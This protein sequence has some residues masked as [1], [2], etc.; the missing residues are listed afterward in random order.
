MFAMAVLAL[1]L[2]TAAAAEGDVTHLMRYADVHGDR[3]V[4]TYEGDLW[5]A[6]TQGGAARRLTSDPGEERFAKFSPDGT[7][8]AFTASYDGGTDVYVMDAGGGAPV[9]F[10]WHPSQD[11][12]LDWF[13]DGRSILFRSRREFPMRGEQIYKVSADGG[14]ETKLPVD[15][16][17]LT[18]LSPDGTQICYNRISGENATWK[19]HQGGDAQSLWLGS[20]AKG[21]F[22]PVAPWKGTTNYPMW[23][24]DT[25]Y[26]SSD[27]E[28]GTMNLFA[29]DPKTGAVRTL[30]RY[31]DYDVKFPSMGPGTIIFQYGEQ[32][33]LMDL[34][35]EQVRK[36]DIRIPSD[37]V[38]VRDEWILATSNNVG[39]GLNPDGSR[40]LIEARGEVLSVP[41][42]KEKGPSYNVT[43]TSASRERY[44]AWSPDGKWIAFLSDKTGEEELYLADVRGEKPWRQ[45]T[46]TGTGYK[47]RPVW[48]PDSARILFSDKFMNLNLVEVS[49]G[50]LT[51][52][53]KAEYDDGWERWGIQDYIFS[54]CSKWIAYTKKLESTNEAIFLYSM[55]AGKAVQ[56]TD[57]LFE[58]WSPSWDPKGR[59]L[60]FLSN[61]SFQPTMGTVDQDHIFLNMAKP[62]VLLLTKSQPSPFAPQEDEVVSSEPKPEASAEKGAEKGKEKPKGKDAQEPKKA[63]AI[64]LEDF[65]SRI[66]E[67]EGVEAGN[68]FRLEAIEKGFLYL[69]KAEPEFM[70]YQVV[71]DETPSQQDLWTYDLKEKKAQESLKG[72]QNYH[73]CADGKKMVYRAGG[74]YGVVDAGPKAKVGDGSVD[75]SDVKIR[76][77]KLGEFRQ[78]FDEAWR[79]ERDWFYD[80]NMHGLDWKA[81]GEKYRKFLPDC[82]NRSDLNYI[83]GEMIAELNIG[84]TYVSGGEFG[85]GGKRVA[86]GLLGCEFETPAGFAFPR[87]AK[88]VPGK[89]WDKDDRSP[90]AAPGLGVREGDYLVAVDGQKVDPKENVYRYF[91]TKGGRVVTLT[92]NSKPSEEGSRTVRVETLRGEGGI[93]YRAWVEANLEKVRKATGG[94]VAY[95]HIPDMDQGGLVEFA[96][97]YY[98]QYTKGGLIIDARY[99]GGGFTGDMI[100]DRLQRKVWSMTQPREGK[101]ARNP[102]VALHGPMVLLINEDTGSN[103]EFFAEAIK[104]KGVARIIGK[105]TWGGSVGIEPHQNL[106]DGGSVTPPQF[107]LYGLDGRWLIE[108]RGVDPDIDIQ[109][110]PE[111]VLQGKDAQLDAAIGT[112]LDEMKKVTPLPAPPAYPNKARPAGSDLSGR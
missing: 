39:F 6:S 111:D 36:L 88:I 15:R 106:V 45:L 12:V 10:T 2:A 70:K 17:G 98:P 77:E 71:T 49:S 11:L 1:L 52:L 35:T 67:A 30:T 46:Q 84:H 83:I 58:S 87:I 112:V 100:L 66:V 101:P 73:L 79:I 33:H 23:Q 107:G 16:A 20:L 44:P 72:V 8:L 82:G 53:D 75:L 54:P 65:E 41:A 21:D 86:V 34:K 61:R 59:Y 105:R 43:R 81:T 95:V 7:K 42:D 68:Y 27:R 63:T 89:A 108:G 51:V 9:R 97:Y 38:K 99:N 32:L 96:R 40:V 25:V 93:R 109:N 56:V 50:K 26:F 28:G 76:V 69:A 91:E 14:T 64:D 62:Y 48:S 78:M 74:K 24:G 110:M 104:F 57:A 60:Y 85:D 90:L 3:V 55:D 19:R 47:L 102:E 4:F 37:R 94:K 18:A 13:P 22:K 29:L 80:K 31:T 92:L 5:L 103:G